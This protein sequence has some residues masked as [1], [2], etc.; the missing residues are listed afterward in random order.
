MK[1]LSN[2]VRTTESGTITFHKNVLQTKI[3]LYDLLYLQHRRSV[4]V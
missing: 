4:N 3:N 1:K 2:F